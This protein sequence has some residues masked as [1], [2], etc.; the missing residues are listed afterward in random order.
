VEEE[1]GFLCHSRGKGL[2]MGWDKVVRK[3]GGNVP[4]KISR[5]KT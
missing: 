5:N 3:A 2:E 4:L 1:A